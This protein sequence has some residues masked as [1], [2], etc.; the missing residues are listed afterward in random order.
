MIAPT[1]PAERPGPSEPQEAPAQSWTPWRV[2][3]GAAVTAGLAALL[4]VMADWERVRTAAAAL[5]VA[6]LAQATLLMGLTQLMRA[7]RLGLMLEL[8]LPNRLLQLLRVAVLH[9]FF[10]MYAPMRVG[11][12]AL[13]WLV[14]REF[15]F[16]YSTSVGVFLFV[17]TLD[18]LFLLG[19]AGIAAWFVVPATSPFAALRLL[20]PAGVAI[21]FALVVAWSAGLG[22][23]LDRLS[24]AGRASR[25]RVVS[26]LAGVAGVA[27]RMDAGRLV[28]IL[29]A[30]CL[31]WAC[32]FAAAYVAVA[33]VLPEPGLAL[34]VWAVDG[35]GLSF[36]LPVTGVANLGTYEATTA[37]ALAVAQVPYEDALLL[38]VLLHAAILLAPVAL[39]PLTLLG[40]G[41]AAR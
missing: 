6:A 5:S 40:R 38:A 11:E 24:V 14:R 23:R 22:R 36:A 3:A 10:S 18:L 21:L 9:N 1:R 39:L 29:G 4:L 27:T 35:G 32:I 16:G 25:N 19:S 2:T 15:R 31:G 34:A 7:V 13:I 17:R 8:Q 33:A 26:A 30:T 41:S 20:G 37:A 12:L 28:Q